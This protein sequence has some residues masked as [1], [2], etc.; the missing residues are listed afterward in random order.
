[1]VSS[2]AGEALGSAKTKNQLSLRWLQA[3]EQIECS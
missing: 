3:G 2:V 1:M